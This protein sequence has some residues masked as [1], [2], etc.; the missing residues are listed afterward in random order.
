MPKPFYEKS[1]RFTQP[2]GTSFDA[3][4]WGDQHHAVFEVQGYTI[5]R[6]PVSGYYYY[7]K[8]SQDGADLEPG[9]VVVGTADPSQ[10]GIQPGIRTSSA[11][12]RSTVDASLARGGRRRR[13]EERRAEQRRRE[14]NARASTRG[15][16]SFAPPDRQTVGD[17][18][19]LCILIQFPDVPGEI[20][21]REVDNY[22]NQEGYRD[23]G[24]NGS[25]RDY[26]LDVSNGRLRYSNIVTGYYTAGNPR[27]YYTNEVI[28]NGKRARELVVEALD[29]LVAAGFDF[30]SLTTDD[31]GYIR[32]LNV[33]YAGPNVNNWSKGLWPHSWHL[34]TEYHVGSE[35]QFYDYQITNM[36]S[37]LTIGTFC[38]ENGHMICDFPDLY[39]YGY[40][41]AGIGDYCLMCAGGDDEKNPVRVGAYLMRSA[42]WADSVT[43]ASPGMSIE[44]DARRN[45][46]VLFRKNADE[47]FLLEN[48]HR[49]GRDIGL[50]D[51]GLAI[52]HI[53][54]NGS[55][56]NEQGTAAQHY[57]CE[58]EQADG[59]RELEFN[60]NHG[61]PGD[62]FSI[63]TNNRF[64]DNSVPNSRWWD[65]TVSGLG[66]VCTSPP[67]MNISVEF[68]GQ[69]RETLEGESSPHLDIPD[70]SSSGVD[71]RI[72][73]ETN[74]KVG[75]IVLQLDITHT[76]LGDLVISLIS[77]SGDIAV[78][79]NRQGGRTQDLNIQLDSTTDP[80]LQ[81]FLGTEAGGDWTLRVQDLAGVD[82][83]VLRHWKLGI[84]P[85]VGNQLRM[86]DSPKVQIP[87]NDPTGISRMLTVDQ[88]KSIATVK[89]EVDIT[90]SYVQ[91]LLLKLTA[92]SGKTV[93][94]HDRAGGSSDNI[95]TTFDS[96][97]T[98]ELETLQNESTAGLWELHVSDL[99]GQDVGKLN[100]WALEFIMNN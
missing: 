13:W 32:A 42:G 20:S 55:N 57:E 79:H 17:Y 3:M 99:E 62:L 40:E 80:A 12:T 98:P 48:R 67:G 87:D 6:D 36:G 81:Q 51:S 33:F 61:G 18:T 65:G 47:Y 45:D 5:V 15:A 1:F 84:V 46:V 74:S 27:A 82:T 60:V 73:L 22:C 28:S 52:W 94:L 70:N 39:D 30:S 9:G 41:S 4:G 38:H 66:I 53:D 59:K 95:I 8:L 92:P 90:H 96:V 43:N 76:Y 44:L 24:N 85:G 100:Q 11:A 63:S 2:D 37:E 78:L 75:S 86:V 7:A 29:N 56:N 89:V 34:A 21:Q 71:D 97:S 49:Q 77:P 69:I 10:I 88:N 25:V 54:E 19:G 31:S 91:D 16:P 68:P 35:M 58:L 64:D 50:P 23:F 93:V 72:T 83:G 26:F 14:L